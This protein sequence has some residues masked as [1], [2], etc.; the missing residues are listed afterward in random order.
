MPLKLAMVFE[1]RSHQSY[2]PARNHFLLRNGL[3][4]KIAFFRAML[5]LATSFLHQPMMS[6]WFLAMQLCLAMKNSI[7]HNSL[8]L[9]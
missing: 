6:V 9:V 8:N 4:I 1:D 5:V 2:S 3:H 7:H